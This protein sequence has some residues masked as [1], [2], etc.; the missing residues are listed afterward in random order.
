MGL[1][2]SRV[3]YV[4]TWRSPC[5]GVIE[6]GLHHH[7]ALTLTGAPSPRH[8]CPTL[9]SSRPIVRSRERTDA[10]SLKSLNSGQGTLLR[11]VFFAGAE[12]QPIS[13]T[14]RHKS[15]SVLTAQLNSGC[16][17]I[18]CMSPCESRSGQGEVLTPQS[19]QADG[20]LAGV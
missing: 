4:L 8:C 6:S 12:Q 11:F 13:G 5:L 14:D 20:S 3:H 18:P 16:P 15:A 2:E 9:F 7:C 1:T 10:G 17:G 19:G